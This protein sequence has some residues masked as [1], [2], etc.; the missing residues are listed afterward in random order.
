VQA[1]TDNTFVAT[2][3]WLVKAGRNKLVHANE[4]FY[5]V[6]GS[7]AECWPVANHAAFLDEVFKLWNNWT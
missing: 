3:T 1:V 2:M 5:L 6:R 4:Q 7:A